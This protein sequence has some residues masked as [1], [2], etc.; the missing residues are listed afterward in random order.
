MSK[1]TDWGAL[2]TDGFLLT[3]TVTNETKGKGAYMG[4]NF[5]KMVRGL[6]VKEL[7]TEDI[8]GF[9]L[10]S[11]DLVSPKGRPF[12]SE[13]AEFWKAE[14]GKLGSVAIYFDTSAFAKSL[15]Q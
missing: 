14:G 15:V 11:Y 1:G 5:F 8:S 2:L 6:R 9:A 12:T 3:G 13:V 10:V 7:I 4:N